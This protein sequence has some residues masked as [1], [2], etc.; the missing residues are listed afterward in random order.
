MARDPARSRRALR[1]SSNRAG[2][3]RRRAPEASRDAI[4]DAALRC[5]AKRGYH[6]TSVD[7]IAA[8]A[9]LSKG[10]V[11]WHFAGKRELFLAL[12]DRAM[13]HDVELARAVGAAPDWRAALHELLARSPAYVERELPLVKLS[14]QHLL[15]GGLDEGIRARTEQKQE[16]WNTIVEKHLARGVAEG[17]LRPFAPGD[18]TLAIG[19]AIAGLTL[20]RLTQP[21]MKLDSVWSVLEE[22]FGKGLE[23]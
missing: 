17:R 3:P 6:E 10:A 22:I 23:T 12:M 15:Q 19:A 13:A 7:D 14:L 4:L 16:R 9:K 8:R 5:F 21:D 1:R 2:R 11:Y 20:L 18:V